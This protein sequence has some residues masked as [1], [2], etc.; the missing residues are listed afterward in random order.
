MIINISLGKLVEKCVPLQLIFDLS[1]NKE[2]V[3]DLRNEFFRKKGLEIKN[4]FLKKRRKNKNDLRYKED[5]VGKYRVGT[6]GQRTKQKIDSEE[7]C[8][9]GNNLDRSSVF[10]ENFK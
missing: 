9:H 10:N 1:Y 8:K 7:I 2:K 4:V 3:K 5:R 6:S